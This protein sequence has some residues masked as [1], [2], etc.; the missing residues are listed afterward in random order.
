MDRGRSS[1]SWSRPSGALQFPHPY[2]NAQLESFQYSRLVLINLRRTD[3]KPFD[4]R[5][6]RA[7]RSTVRLHRAVRV[8]SARAS[9][10][11]RQL[12]K[13]AMRR[14]TCADGDVGAKRVIWH[15]GFERNLRR[16][17]ATLVRG[18][19]R[20]PALRRAAR[21]D[22]LLLRKLA[23]G[24]GGGDSAETLRRLWPLLAARFGGRIQEPGPPLSV[25]PA[26]PALG[27][28]AHVL[29]QSARPASP[30]RRW[31]A[32]SRRPR[33][34]R[35]VL[36]ARGTLRGAGRARAHS[37]PRCRRREHGPAPGRTW[38]AATSGSTAACSPCTWWRS[39]SSGPPRAMICY[40]R[41]ATG[42]SSRPRRAGSG[43]S[44]WDRRRPR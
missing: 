39:T 37:Q 11:P 43:W 19:L 29:R 25:R 15:V 2:G 36:R 32:P 5:L 44:W 34:V 23:G 24:R 9:L 38:A 17:G 7:P 42:S 14:A 3:A 22:Y 27:L 40:I 31:H 35:S 41:S 28:R 30:A 10:A 8:P 6:Q 26:R 4:R 18:A 12:E 21:L 20:G 33:A 16:R 13:L 1:I